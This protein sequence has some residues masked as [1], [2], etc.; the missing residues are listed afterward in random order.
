MP[1]PVGHALAGFASAW[2][3][4]ALPLNRTRTKP[5]VAGRVAWVLG[6]G[7]AIACATV[8]VLPDLDVVFGRHRG[9]SHSLGAAVLTGVVA[10]GVA[11][12]W[13]A[14]RLRTAVTCGAAVASHVLL[15]WLAMDLT[16]PFGIM[17]LWP[18]ST[19]YYISGADL[20]MEVSRRY[21]DPREF[22]F[23]NLAG[24]AVELCIL[25]PI[26]AAAWWIGPARCRTRG[27]AGRIPAARDGGGGDEPEEPA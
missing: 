20:F 4:Q 15:D 3:A 7:L 25:V 27:G 8:A 6:G 18:L 23:R 13:Q 26:A 12:L 2:V 1:G 5:Q 16:P 24:F 19:S 22:I 11:S 14:P 21:W 17:A 10:W 9:V